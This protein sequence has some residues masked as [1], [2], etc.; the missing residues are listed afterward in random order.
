[1]THVSDTKCAI[2]SAVR[3][4]RARI[5]PS[6]RAAAA[7]AVAHALV[8]LPELAAVRCVLAYHSTAEELDTAPVIHALRARGVRIALPRIDDPGILDIHEHTEDSVLTAGPHGILEPLASAPRVNE[9]DIDAVLVPAIAFGVDGFRIGYGGGFY[10]RLLPRFH[11][12]CWRVGVAF[13]EQIVAS[14]PVEEHDQRVD[15]IVT[16]SRVFRLGR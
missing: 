2:R 13:D 9:P 7:E 3:S 16:P 8:D 10:D 6:E 5:E 11:S 15:L 12:G 14:V 4:A 1:M